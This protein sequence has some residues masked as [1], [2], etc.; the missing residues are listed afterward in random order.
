MALPSLGMLV[1]VVSLF[2][3]KGLP[4]AWTSVVCAILPCNPCFL[5]SLGFGIWGIVVLCDSRV[6]RAMQ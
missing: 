3:G 1:G 5:I 4:M 2:R 6:T